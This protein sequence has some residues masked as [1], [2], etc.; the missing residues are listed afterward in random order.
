MDKKNIFIITCDQMSW[1]AMKVFGNTFVNTPNIDRLTKDSVKFANN[2]TACPMCIPARAAYWT[3]KYPHETGAVANLEQL[4]HVD[5]SIPTI[6]ETF[7]NAGYETVHFGTCHDCGGLRGFDMHLTPI[8]DA[9]PIPNEYDAFPLSLDTFRDEFTANATVEYIKTLK[10]RSKNDDRPLLLVSEFTNPHNICGFVTFNAFEHD[11]KELP[12]GFELPPLPENYSFDDIM[13]RPD[14]V[15]YFCC[16]LNLQSWVSKWTDENFRHYI[17]AYYY[18][19]SVLDNHIGRLL[20]AYEEYGDVENTMFVFFADHG[21]SMAARRKVT[22][23]VD[24]YEETTR[25]P[26]VFKGKDVVPREKPIE[27]I[28]T[29]IDLFPT[30]CAMADIEI[31]KTL[32]GK[33]LSSI[34]KGGEFNLERKYVIS[35]WSSMFG[36]IISPARMLCTGDYKYTYYLEDDFEEL[37]DLKL[38]PYEKTNVA[39]HENYKEILSQMQIYFKEYLEKSNDPLMSLEV[40]VDRE[41]WRSH[42]KRVD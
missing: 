16:D 1:R 4:Q 41:K 25:V 3:S 27:N 37:Y 29:T 15:K 11:D 8:G 36:N 28:T 19:I 9:E 33:D 14:A 23:S 18:Y 32:Q 6:G 10:E 24:F 35:Q 20:D 38:D 40:K 17:A 34:L 2:Y 5:E 42:S 21:D 31:P 39:K 26:F 7:K 30:L 22:K 12:E 13:N